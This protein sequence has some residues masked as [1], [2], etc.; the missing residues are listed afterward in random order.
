MAMEDWQS[1]YSYERVVDEWLGIW[2]DELADH[3]FW[4]RIRVDGDT[5]LYVL[6]LYYPSHF[7]KLF[8]GLFYIIYNYPMDLNWTQPGYIFCG[9]D[10]D[11]LGGIW[12]GLISVY[13]PNLE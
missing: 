10:D 2:M 5:I 8:C 1:S 7:K 11:W 9:G 4:L 3:L 6:F 13:V 12:V